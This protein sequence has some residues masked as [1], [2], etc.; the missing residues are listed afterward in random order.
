[1]NFENEMFEHHLCHFKI[2]YD[3]IFHRTNGLYIIRGAA[4]H[5][6]CVSAH[7]HNSGSPFQVGLYRDHGRLGQ[8]NA[9]PTHVNQRVGRPE[10]DGHVI[11]KK[12]GH[13]VENHVGLFRLQRWVENVAQYL[14]ESRPFIKRSELTRP[15]LTTMMEI[16]TIQ[17]T[18]KRRIERR[19]PC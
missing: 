15:K 2:R 14:A 5:F 9:S 3:A 13:P 18:H 19:R 16:L 17:L 11:R 4:Q 1:M 12:S 10:I 8:N 6:L 7:R